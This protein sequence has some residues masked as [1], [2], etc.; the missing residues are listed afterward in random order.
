MNKHYDFILRGQ[1]IAGSLLA[2]FLKQRGKNILVVDPNKENTS[3]RVAA[4]MI[5]P[6]TGRRIVKSWNADV[7]IPFARATY[8]N[9]EDKLADKFFE[10]YPVLEIFKDTGHRN[11]WAGRSAS[12]GMQEY[13]KGECPPESIP[14]GVKAPEGGRWVVNGGWLDTR[15]F[16]DAI[17]RYLKQSESFLEDSLHYEEVQFESERVLWKNYSAT[18][19]IDCSGSA[20][21]A[22]PL[23]AH[24]PFKPCKGEMLQIKVEGLP[25]DIILHNS[26][27][28]IPLGGYQYLCG[29]TYDFNNINEETTEEG[30][31]KITEALEKIISVPYSI[32]THRAA[33]RPSTIDRKPIASVHPEFPQLY[34]FNGLG[35]KGVMMG[36]SIANMIAESLVSQDEFGEELKMFII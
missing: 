5:H 33:I 22:H 10:E 12:E 20:A 36:P 17:Q 34:I 7:F 30:K 14:N 21:I 29:A 31:S 2:W 18:K 35:S 25:K 19:I 3:S 6:V 28:V 26:I 13:V 27:K 1:G 4:G 9:I 24:L 8:Q 32:S 15:R 23:F 16:L 11:D